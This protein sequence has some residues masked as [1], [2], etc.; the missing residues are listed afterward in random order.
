MPAVRMTGVRIVSGMSIVSGVGRMPFVRSMIRVRS[1][2]AVRGVRGMIRM[3]GVVSVRGMGSVSAVSC[4]V[5]MSGVGFGGHFLVP[6]N[7]FRAL[8]MIKLIPP[9]GI[10]KMAVSELGHGVRI[11]LTATVAHHAQFDDR[12]TYGE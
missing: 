7:C 12:Q 4:V 8:Q 3:G 6:L 5:V 9:R 11:T 2:V 1:V 10:S